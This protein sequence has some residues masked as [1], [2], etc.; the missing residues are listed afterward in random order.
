MSVLATL[1]RKL[2]GATLGFISGYLFATFSWILTSSSNRYE[3][4]LLKFCSFETRSMPNFYQ[5]ATDY[6]NADS[7]LCF[8]NFNLESGLSTM[9]STLFGIYAVQNFDSAKIRGR[10]TTADDLQDVD[11]WWK[12]GELFLYSLIW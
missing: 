6:A 3:K 5:T 9:P 8:R 10:P 7:E 2:A 1:S 11:I 4:T 12:A